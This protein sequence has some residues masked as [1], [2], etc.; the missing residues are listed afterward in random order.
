MLIAL[1]VTDD[2]LGAEQCAQLDAQGFV[3]LPGIIGPERLAELRKRLDELVESE[4]GAAGHDVALRQQGALVLGDLF[5]KGEA[6]ERLLNTAPVLAAARHVLGDF[7]V[8]SLNCRVAPPGEGGQH[9]HSD[10][11]LP[12]PDGSF[13]IV[14]SIWLVDDFTAVNGATRAVPGSHRWGRLPVDDMPDPFADH[15]DQQLLTGRAGDVV[16]FNA[17]VWHGGTLNASDAP[18]RGL[19]LAFCR[20]DERQQTDQAERIR[21]RVYDRLSAGERF[22][23]DV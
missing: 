20:R 4:S 10:C 23:L 14:N 12:R 3:R 22:L 6:F 5:N 19:T 17:H 15:P 8:S 13:R 11:G 9:L 1:G 18:R 21:K 2:V 16:V 7:K